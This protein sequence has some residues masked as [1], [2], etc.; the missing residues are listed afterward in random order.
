MPCPFCVFNN[1]AVVS[2]IVDVGG[3]VEIIAEWCVCKTH[4]F[5]K[6]NEYTKDKGGDCY[7]TN[8]KCICT[9]GT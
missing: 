4:S 6:R 3:V 8:I 7:G 9:S 2:R 1:F 5:R